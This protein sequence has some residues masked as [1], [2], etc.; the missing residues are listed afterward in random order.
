[1]N[2][3]IGAAV[4]ISA[5]IVARVASAQGMLLDFAADKVIKKYQT[6]TCDELK[7]Q[8]KEPPTDKEKEA[9]QFLRN[10]S[11]ARIF[12]INKIAAPVLNKM[13]E[14]GMIP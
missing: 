10:D 1:M 11:Q 7:A 8:R 6:A 5:L 2:K 4:L 3:S 9:V 13:Y 12:F 14:C